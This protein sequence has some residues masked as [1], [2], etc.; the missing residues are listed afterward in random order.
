MFIG[1]HILR[2]S[3]LPSTNDYALNLVKSDKPAEGTVVIT[4]YQ[5]S[6]KGQ[7]GN[8]WQSGKDVN[9]TCSIILYPGFLQASQQFLLNMAMAL[10]MRNAVSAVAG[11]SFAIKWPNDLFGFDKKVGGMLIENSI[12][13]SFIQHSVVGFGVNLNQMHF[14]GVPHAGSLKMLSG[15]EFDASQLL[16]Q[17]MQEVEWSY[18]Q[19]RQGQFEKIHQAFNTALYRKDMQAAFS[20]ANGQT[21]NARI[22]G[23]D[24]MGNIQLSTAD[25]LTMSFQH[26]QIR[27]QL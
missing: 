16:H 24:P 19:L 4:D 7:R 20:L 18:L 1:N 11:I 2:F 15:S 12:S 23:V 9:L 21:L 6:G 25:G 8:T 22:N 17:L 3:E 14:E 26:H 27:M 13:G 5:T 10:A